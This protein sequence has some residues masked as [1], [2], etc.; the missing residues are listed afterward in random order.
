ME[1]AGRCCLKEGGKKGSMYLPHFPLLTS[2]FLSLWDDLLERIDRAFQTYGHALPRRY[3]R[4]HVWLLEQALLISTQN[5]DQSGWEVVAR[6]SIDMLC[7]FDMIE[8]TTPGL[9]SPQNNQDSRN[10][11]TKTLTQCLKAVVTYLGPNYV[12][13]VQNC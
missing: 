9:I 7:L 3:E 4:I 11:C 6:T 12:L 1:L 2:C 10:R 13:C 5:R 8:E